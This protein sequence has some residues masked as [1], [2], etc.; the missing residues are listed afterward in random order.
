M[1]AEDLLHD[2][3]RDGVRMTIPEDDPGGLVLDGPRSAMTAGLVAR[4]K[5]HKPGLL[6][7]LADAGTKTSAGDTAT[8]GFGSGVSDTLTATS[9][10]AHESRMLADAPADLRAA[11][12]SVKQA[13]PGAELIRVEAPEPDL[14]A[15]VWPADDVVAGLSRDVA[16]LVRPRDGWT[17]W[18]WRDRL[19]YLAGACAA[20]HPDRATTLRRAA[21]T[22]TPAALEDFE[23]RAAIME[24]DGGLSRQDAEAAAVEDVLISIVRK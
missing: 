13:F 11:V 15:P 20:L 18:E 9:Y 4:V 3:R 8:R 22:L 17:A 14:D 24:H 10:T 12:E 23:E 2:L 6:A 1:T 19:L 5:V 16:A 7:L 21:I